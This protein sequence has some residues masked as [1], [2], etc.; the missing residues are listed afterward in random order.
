MT[1]LWQALK[2]AK[3]Q[4]EYFL[5]LST[6]ADFSNPQLLNK[7][8]QYAISPDVRSQDAV[9]LISTVMQNPAG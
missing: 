5:Y 1:K 2:D 8:L 3:T 9:G 7:T 6:L 4:E